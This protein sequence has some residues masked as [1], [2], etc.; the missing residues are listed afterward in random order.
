MVLWLC[1][2]ACS[3]PTTI[4]VRV[5]LPG[6]DS[7]DA[8]VTGIGVVALPYDRDSVLKAL[9]AGAAHPRPDTAALDSLY[10]A[11]RGPFGAFSRGAYVVGALKDSATRVEAGSPGGLRLAA[12][13][14][15]A[16]A[17]EATARRSLDE[18]RRPFDTRVPKLRQA[19]RAWEDTTYAEYGTV[20]RQ[21]VQRADPV[22]D[23]T[24]AEGLAHLTPGNGKWW[25]YARAFDTNDP[26]A[27]WYWNVPVAGDT[28]RL[29]RANA[30]H[31]PRY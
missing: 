19:I 15:A 25:L 17:A 8:P 12:A 4:T 5:L 30:Q 20:T 7:A 21:L 23:T 10:A 13:L 3:R 9:R 29:T 31:H 2:A 16:E 18:A 27:E 6:L 28:V 22:T 1:L 14:K 24:N 26:N 11:F